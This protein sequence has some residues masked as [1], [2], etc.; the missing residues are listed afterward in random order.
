MCFFFLIFIFICLFRLNCGMQGLWS[1]L[2]HSGSFIA[3]FELLVG[4][5]SK[6]RDRIEP[7]PRALGVQSL[8]Q[9]T[10]REVPRCFFWP[11][12]YPDTEYSNLLAPTNR[13]SSI[14][15]QMF[16]E[17]NGNPLQYSGL[18]NPMDGGAWQATAHGVTELDRT[19]QL[20]F[21]FQSSSNHWLK[22]C[23]A[24]ER[25]QQPRQWF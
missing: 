25:W 12:L 21:H 1:S 2:Q 19:E 24:C 18:E 10:T 15:G 6:T 20:H 14:K 5:S 13:K 9:W 16:G 3:A 7:R 23:G 17:A 8:S 22:H 11:F 4:S